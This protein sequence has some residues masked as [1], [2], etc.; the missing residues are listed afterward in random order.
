MLGYI[1]REGGP[2]S[3]TVQESIDGLPKLRVIGVAD[4]LVRADG[5][6]VLTY[7]QAL[8]KA[9]TPIYLPRTGRD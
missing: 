5:R 7:H 1:R 4:D 3:W 6:D 8:Q 9:A 2:G